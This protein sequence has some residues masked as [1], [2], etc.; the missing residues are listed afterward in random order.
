MSSVLSPSSRQPDPAV[1]EAGEHLQYLWARRPWRPQEACNRDDRPAAA[2]EHGYPQGQ[3]MTLKT[4]RIDQ[5][6]QK[7]HKAQ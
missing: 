5:L 1:W 6:V 7:S 3:E 2:V 4:P